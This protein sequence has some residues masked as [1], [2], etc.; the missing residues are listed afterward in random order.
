MEYRFQ[1]IEEK[2]ICQDLR[3][4]MESNFLGKVTA[5]NALIVCY[6]RAI[7]EF[8][9]NKVDTPIFDNMMLLKQYMN[10]FEWHHRYE[11]EMRANQLFLGC[12][13]EDLFRE[14]DFQT[15]ILHYFSNNVM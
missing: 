4:Y 1:R 10:K 7:R 2:N 15:M 14:E 6:N 5:E 13:I 12:E 9:E 11:I 3:R 8:Y